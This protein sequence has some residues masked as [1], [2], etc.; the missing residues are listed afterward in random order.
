ML[1]THGGAA[2]AAL[3]AAQAAHE[4][5]AARAARLERV[6]GALERIA[7]RDGRGLSSHRELSLEN[8]VLPGLF[9]PPPLTLSGGRVRC[10]SCCWWWLW[11]LSLKHL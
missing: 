9:L 6:R 10:C 3:G 1:V 2:A 8:Q 4:A 11:W 5:E 7:A